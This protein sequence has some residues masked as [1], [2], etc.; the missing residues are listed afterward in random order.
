MAVCH[1][2]HEKMCCH[3]EGICTGAYL[4]KA[5]HVP[6]HHEEEAIEVY[7]YDV[8]GL[9]SPPRGEVPA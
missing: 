1:L 2:P 5:L 6:L 9:L 7:R 3:N 4:S 8:A